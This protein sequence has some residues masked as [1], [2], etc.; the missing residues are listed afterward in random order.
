MD[1]HL[2]TRT[3]TYARPDAHARAH[4]QREL[5]RGR[6]PVRVYPCT[7]ARV[8]ACARVRLRD[9]VPICLRA[10]MPTRLCACI[11]VCMLAWSRSGPRS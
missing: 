9:C 10:S 1:K 2:R 7:S 4:E 5:M 8:C 3:S 11:Y 6:V